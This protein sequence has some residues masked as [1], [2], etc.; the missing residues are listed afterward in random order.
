MTKMILLHN[1]DRLFTSHQ[2]PADSERP[3]FYWYSDR[4]VSFQGTQKYLYIFV[5]DPVEDNVALRPR[6]SG[7]RDFDGL[8][9]D[10][11]HYKAW[12]EG[13][14]DEDC[15][16]ISKNLKYAESG[17]AMS[18]SELKPTV[19]LM[20]RY[21]GSSREEWMATDFEIISPVKPFTK[22]VIKL[23]D[24]P[25]DKMHEWKPT[26]FTD[27]PELVDLIPDLNDC[28]PFKK[29][30][31]LDDGKYHFDSWLPMTSHPEGNWL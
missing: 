13:R 30:E 28:L 7:T 10:F 3:F 23:F 2:P 14:H 22:R 11:L 27:I 5:I 6:R 17:I 29:I 4:F 31:K 16:C 19:T 21:Y 26:R 24:E 20:N 8:H 9:K 18:F 25:Y 1:S 12:I 15:W